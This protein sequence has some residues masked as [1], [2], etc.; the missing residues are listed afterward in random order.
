MA[1]FLACIGIAAVVDDHHREKR[2]RQM[3]NDIR[4]LDGEVRGEHLM[5]IGSVVT[6]IQPASSVQIWQTKFGR[7]GRVSKCA[8]NPAWLNARAKI[9][10]RDTNSYL[11]RY[12]WV[13]VD[14]ATILVPAQN[15]KYIPPVDNNVT[16][17]AAAGTSVTVQHQEGSVVQQ[18]VQLQP[19][20]V[21]QGVVSG[22][23]V[24]TQATAPYMVQGQQ[25]AHVAPEP[26]AMKQSQAAP[27]TTAI[28]NA[29]V[30]AQP[31]APAISQGM[32]VPNP[33]ATVPPSHY[34]ILEETTEMRLARENEA[35]KMEIEQL[36]QQAANPNKLY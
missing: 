28:Q 31:I 24:A 29:P 7:D 10:A 12:W 30:N 34:P 18:E 5:Q 9:V 14:G 3:Q 13:F 15:L 36:R 4:R 1:L 33:P 32:P 26:W 8:W 11:A 20:P 2:R 35:L 27:V 25:I 19:A 16:I 17:H 21:Q 23:P 6:I 22:E